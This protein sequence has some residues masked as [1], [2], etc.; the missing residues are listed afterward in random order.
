MV[1][2]VGVRVVAAVVGNLAVV[3][4]PQEVSRQE[5]ALVFIACA[6]AP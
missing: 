3:V 1:V 5:V 6:H 4:V 2:V